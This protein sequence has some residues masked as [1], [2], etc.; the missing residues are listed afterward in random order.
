VDGA[1]VTAGEFILEEGT[2]SGVDEGVLV[3]STVGLFEG[4]ELTVGCLL[5]LGPSLGVVDGTGLLDGRVV[6]REEVFFVGCQLGLFEGDSDSVGIMEAL[7]VP[8][9]ES[10]GFTVEVGPKLGIEVVVGL[11]EGEKE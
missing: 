10:L 8:E 11:D 6:G 1:D 2:L 4:A 9:G 5:E 7:G 3:G